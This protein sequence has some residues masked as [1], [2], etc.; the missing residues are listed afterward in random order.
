MRSVLIGKTRSDEDLKRIDVSDFSIIVPIEKVESS[1]VIFTI[2]NESGST[3]EF[4]W[5]SVCASVSLIDSKLKSM[6]M[7]KIFFNTFLWI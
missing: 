7:N 1:K 2:L 5:F 3:K 6:I 4:E